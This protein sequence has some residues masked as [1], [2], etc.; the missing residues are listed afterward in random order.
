[1]TEILLDLNPLN[2]SDACVAI[3]AAARVC[4]S[5]NF[6][7]RKLQR[8]YIAQPKENP[9]QQYMHLANI[10]I[11]NYRI[12][13]L[14]RVNSI[15][16]IRDDYR[17][18][19]CCGIEFDFDEHRLNLCVYRWCCDDNWIESRYDAD[20]SD[21]LIGLVGH[22]LLSITRENDPCEGWPY[23]PSHGSDSCDIA[24]RINI[25]YGD[26]LVLTLY[27]FNSSGGKYPGIFEV[28]IQ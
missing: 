9:R 18:D 27:H 19:H 14:G 6:W 5:D 10:N 2:L 1:M 4:R 21:V 20:P 25:T 3:P 12:Y 13:Q 7:K 15:R 11:I 28:T 23:A 16:I 8:D 22:R 17:E 26:G 24:H